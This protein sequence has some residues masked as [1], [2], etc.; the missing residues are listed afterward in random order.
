[1]RTTAIAAGAAWARTTTIATRAARATWATA[2]AAAIARGTVTGGR[3]LAITACATTTCTTSTC[4]VAAGAIA[5]LAVTSTVASAITT[6][7]TAAISTATAEVTTTI[8]TPIVPLLWRRHVLELFASLGQQGRQ[9]LNRDALERAEVGFGQLGVFKVTQQG[10]ALAALAFFLLAALVL[11]GAAAGELVL[12]HLAVLV[13][14]LAGGLAVQ[15]KTLLA[16]R[17]GHQVGRGTR[18]ATEEG[19]QSSLAEFAG[20]TL[21][22]VDLDAQLQGLGLALEQGGEQFGQAGRGLGRGGAGHLGSCVGRCGIGRHRISRRSICSRGICRP[23]L[24]LGVH[25][26]HSSVG[27]RNAAFGLRRRRTL[28]QVSGVL[29]RRHGRRRHGERAP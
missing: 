21:L 4:T 25:G 27:G 16:A 7:I 6:R 2:G 13:G 10:Q 5:A 29:G 11:L 12:G 20:R 22:Q 9:G 1:M 26:R 17:H 23:S 8:T 24:G 28:G 19:R 18:V 15:V 3:A 14:E